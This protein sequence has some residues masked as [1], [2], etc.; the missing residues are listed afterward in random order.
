MDWTC[1][2]C[3]RPIPPDARGQVRV[4]GITEQPKG[5]AW[6]WGPVPVHEACR[7]QLH[8][9]FDDKVGDGYCATWQK[10]KA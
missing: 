7:T 5:M 4:E 1:H 3:L 2:V 8:T 10:M 9:P 6:V